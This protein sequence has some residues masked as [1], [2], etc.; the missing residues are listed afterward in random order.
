MSPTNAPVNSFDECNVFEKVAQLSVIVYDNNK[1]NDSNDEAFSINTVWNCRSRYANF[2]Y[3]NRPH[4]HGIRVRDRK[5]R[6]N[7]KE[8]N[9]TCFEEI[10]EGKTFTSNLHHKKH[11]EVF[12]NAI[13]K[14]R[15]KN[16]C[17]WN[18][19]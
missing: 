13:N 1:L 3:F 9:Y 6:Q 16:I 12:L 7:T 10:L 5:L 11:T 15:A 4:T 2:V 17:T 18:Q 19:M 14:A 8:K